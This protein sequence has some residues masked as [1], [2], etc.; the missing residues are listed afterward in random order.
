MTECMAET[1]QVGD[2]LR[3]LR[4]MSAL[5]KALVTD[6]EIYPDGTVAF[7]AHVVA[8]SNGHSDLPVGTEF[9][10]TFGPEQPVHADLV[11][12]TPKRWLTVEVIETRTYS[13]EAV[14][15]ID[16]KHQ[17]LGI[18]Q[19]GLGDIQRKGRTETEYRVRD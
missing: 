6:R 14:D 19:Y 5:D 4:G 11:S 12:Y 10:L 8:D 16:A 18:P 3:E 17:V 13:V 15:G 2:Y 1:V 9:N 7:K